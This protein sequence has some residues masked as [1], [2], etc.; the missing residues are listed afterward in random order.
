VR[1]GTSNAP[2]QHEPLKACQ[3]DAVIEANIPLPDMLLGLAAKVLCG[4]CMR[5]GES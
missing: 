4:F 1:H 2:E 5:A 3:S